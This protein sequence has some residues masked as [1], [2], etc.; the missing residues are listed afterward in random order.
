MD[1]A[2]Q[3][4]GMAASFLGLAIG[5]FLVSL[6]PPANGLRGPVPWLFLGGGLL[7]VA[8]AVLRMRR[9]RPLLSRMDST[10]MGN[11][12]MFASQLDSHMGELL[13]QP[14]NRELPPPAAVWN[15][16]VLR[17][18][19][20]RRFEAVCV[21]LFAQ[22]GF[23]TRTELQGL[24][25]GADI[26]LYAHHAE[27]PAAVARVRHWPGRQVEVQELREL[28]ALMTQHKLLRA[29]F[30]TTGTFGPD[31]REF[32]KAHGIS[33]FDS[34]GLLALISQR[35]QAQKQELLA[36]AYEGDYWRPSCANCGKKMV[37]RRARRRGRTF[38]GCVDYPDCDF[39]LPVKKPRNPLSFSGGNRS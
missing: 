26:W 4:M 33:A 22:G 14:S 16:Q 2:R 37:E 28:H 21:A 12:S 39:S 9:G 30:A 17:D 34:L 31:G 10:Q 27:V 3:L 11:T 7:A 32:A 35:T 1:P 29:S 38:W 5:L 25:G 15:A 36:I 19:E 20:W 23:T 6:F 18:I 13:D 8:A 24:Q